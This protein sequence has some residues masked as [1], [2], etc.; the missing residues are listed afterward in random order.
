MKALV[1]TEPGY[2]KLELLEI[3]TPCPKDNEVLIK[4]AYTGICGT[5]IHG[6]KGEYDR[7]K[8]PLVLGHEFSGVVEAIGEKVTSV[9]IG[10][11]VTS[12]TTFDTCGECESC[13]NKEYNLCLNRKGLGSQVNGSFAE[14]VLTREESIHI[15]DEKSSLLAAAI[16]EPIA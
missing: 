4:V 9:S 15:L 2:N 1:K 13:K 7:L 12:E 16:T 5:D 11:Q 3:E 14:Y 8:T 10:D 6:F